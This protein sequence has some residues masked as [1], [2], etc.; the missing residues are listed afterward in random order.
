MQERVFIVCCLRMSRLVIFNR[1]DLLIDNVYVQE[2]LAWSHAPHSLSWAQPI[3][4]LQ[5]LKPLQTLMS[6]NKR[7]NYVRWCYLGKEIWVDN[8]QSKK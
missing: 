5:G 6:F 4:V 3:T 8:R 7:Q 1:T 2:A